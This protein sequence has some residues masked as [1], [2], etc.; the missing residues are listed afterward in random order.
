MNDDC[1]SEG[2]IWI[3]KW[4]KITILKCKKTRRTRSVLHFRR[5]GNEKNNLS[6]F[7]EVDYK[8]KELHFI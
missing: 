1:R 8:D 2:E 7:T 3:R 6:E 5:M 4:T